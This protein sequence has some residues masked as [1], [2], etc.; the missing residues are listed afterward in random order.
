MSK[1][2]LAA[3][4][5]LA[6]VTMMAATSAPSQDFPTRA[7]RIVT[8]G[9]GSLSDVTLR[10]ITPLLTT[11]LGRPVIVENIA[12]V[13]TAAESVA[14]AAPDGHTLFTGGNQVWIGPLMQKM[15]YDPVADFAPI[16]LAAR[17]TNILVVH[18][19]LPVKSV[20]ELIG[21][22]KARLGALNYGAGG[23]GGT[24]HLSGELFKAMAKVNIVFINFKNSN[25]AMIGVVS[26]EIQIFFAPSGAAVPHIKSGRVKALAITSAR[27]SALTPGLPT[28]AASGLPGY[29]ADALVGVFAPVKTPAAVVSRLNQEIVRALGQPEVKDRLSNAAA[30]AGGGTPDNLAIAVKSDMVRFGKLI[31]D[32][33]IRIE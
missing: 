2:Y 10:L 14:K 33:G 26:G 4:T 12:S 22:A 19:S 6:A 27:P 18:P 29:E 5:L 24:G 15:P 25:A 30:E 32:A 9:T 23:I 17:T 21:L 13:V 7:V 11:S 16:A 31:K 8:G 3:R 20:K 28:I 1:R